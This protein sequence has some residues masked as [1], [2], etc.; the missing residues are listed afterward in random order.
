MFSRKKS[1]L[2]KMFM[3]IFHKLAIKHA[4]EIKENQL[5]EMV[6]WNHS[7]HVFLNV[8]F[9]LSLYY[10]YFSFHFRIKIP[11][12]A[13]VTNC[14]TNFNRKQCR[15]VSR[16]NVS[17]LELYVGLARPAR[18]APSYPNIMVLPCW[19]HHDY[20]ETASRQSQRDLWPINE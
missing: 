13:I 8:Q 9:R 14:I 7:M 17:S 3:F 18:T 15:Y 5:K 12:R 11:T 2:N 16:V 10:F 6:N 4:L 20:A 1:K 19:P